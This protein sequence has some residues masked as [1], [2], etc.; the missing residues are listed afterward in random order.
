M[1]KLILVAFTILL[2]PSCSQYSKNLG[3]KAQAD[4]INNHGKKIGKAVF[5][6]GSHGV[7][8]NIKARNLPAGRHGM[9][10]HRVGNCSDLKKFKM[11]KGHVMPKGKPHG[12]LN[13]KGPHAGNLTN[14]M[15]AKNG[16][17]EVELYSQMISLNGDLLDSD[18]ASL[19]IH[20]NPDDHKTQPIGGSGPRIACGII[21]N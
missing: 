5:V 19:V 9:H 16:R 13:K 21:K 6:Q 10:F 17:V 14:L 15:V 4:L 11:A 2:T 20:K 3:K 12:F 1:K 8:I 7:L 18:G